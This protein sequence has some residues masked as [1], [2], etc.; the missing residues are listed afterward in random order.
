MGTFVY[1]D[2]ICAVCASLERGSGA[3][4]PHLADPRPLSRYPAVG[5]RSDEF[6]RITGVLPPLETGHVTHLSPFAISSYPNVG[7]LCESLPWG[8]VASM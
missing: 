2:E 4:G 6:G 1:Q 8:N 3:T 5:G 7:D